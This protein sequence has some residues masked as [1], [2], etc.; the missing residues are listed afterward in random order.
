MDF[1]TPAEFEAPRPGNLFS[2][3]ERGIGPSEMA[4]AILQGSS[5]FRTSKEL[6]LHVLEV[7][8]GMLDSGADGSFHSMTTSCTIPSAFYDKTE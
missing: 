6:G 4:D 7:L 8:Q 1:S 2:G 3:N 5:S